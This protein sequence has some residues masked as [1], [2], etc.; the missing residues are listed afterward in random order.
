MYDID[1]SIYSNSLNKIILRYEESKR[2]ENDRNN[3]GK[4]DLY[5]FNDWEMNLFI[6]LST[7]EL[8]LQYYVLFLDLMHWTND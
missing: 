2:S 7:L 1:I 6:D 4:I 8:D 3:L 5:V